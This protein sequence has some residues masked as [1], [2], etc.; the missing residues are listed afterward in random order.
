[1]YDSKEFV[2]KR[3]SMLIAPAGF[4]KTYTVAECLSQITESGKQL[5][6]THTHAGI[7]SIKEKILAANLA[8]S[9][10]AVETIT[11]FAQ[12]YV[13]SFYC[14]NIPEQS[15]SGNYYPFIINIANKI[16]KRKSILNI[17]SRTYSGLFIDEYQDCTTS[18]HDLIMSLAEVLPTRIFGDHLQGIFGFNGELL[19]DMEDSNVMGEFFDNKSTLDK[20]W[21]WIKG[22]NELLGSD[23]QLIRNR[24]EKNELLNLSEFK[25]IETVIINEEDLYNPI[26]NY[27]QKISSLLEERSLLFIHPVSTSIY[28]REKFVG[29]FNNR[30]SLIESIDEKDF[31]N[32]SK[33]ADTITS[34][35][36]IL[37]IRNLSYSLFKE[38]GNDIWFNEWG[39]RQKKNEKDKILLR[40]ITDKIELLRQNVSYSLLSQVLKDIRR[41]P[42]IRC[43]RRELFHSFCK[44]L[45]GAELN[46]LSA[47]QAMVSNR[48]HIR[49]MGRKIYGKCIGTTLLTKGLEF[50]TV[51]ILNA[52]KFI[53][54][55]DLYVALTRASKRLIVF[56]NSNILN[57]YKLLNRESISRQL[58]LDF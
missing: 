40:S 23:L 46:K 42:E 39:F 44:A 56:T 14:G 13:L 19:V 16:F 29:R 8:N 33:E 36:V 6:L 11:S 15:D 24:I 27:R 34:E 4:G 52:H 31:Y 35:N 18:Q 53:S 37:K 28:P 20:P 9:K 22:N 49:R 41:L 50:E 5:V 47:Y 3:K 58:K 57:P 43:N 25:S 7:S 2:S 21:R 38:S 48:N 51:A 26:K 55:K 12:K 17:L 32:L 30:V 1:M 45:E 10:Y 54:K